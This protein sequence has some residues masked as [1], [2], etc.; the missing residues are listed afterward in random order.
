MALPESPCGPTTIDAARTGSDELA[1]PGSVGDT[2]AHSHHHQ[3][4]SARS[5]VVRPS[6]GQDRPDGVFWDSRLVGG[7]VYVPLPAESLIGVCAAGQ[8]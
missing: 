4:T 5:D 1:A 8:G 2:E 7:S 3:C 6:A